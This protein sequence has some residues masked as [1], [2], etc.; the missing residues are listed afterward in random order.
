MCGQSHY[1]KAVKNIIKIIL[2]E[3][4]P[5]W[6]LAKIEDRETGLNTVSIHDILDHAF[7]YRGQIDDDL[8]DEYTNIYNSPID[9]LKGFNMCFERQEECYDF[10]EDAEQP[11]TNIQLSVKVQLHIGQADLFK[12]KEFTECKTLNKL[13]SCEIGFGANA[14]VEQAQSNMSELEEAMDNLAYA[15]TTTNNFL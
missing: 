11:T 15:A 14:A 8:V 6:M 3:A 4:L 7:D 13:T 9:M 10:F 1:Q 5:H 12:D 2:D